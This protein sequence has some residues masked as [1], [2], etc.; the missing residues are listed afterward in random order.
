MGELRLLSQTI[1]RQA[2]EATASGSPQAMKDL[3]ES[4][5]TFAKNIKMSKI[6]MVHLQKNIKS[7]DSV[8][9]FV[10]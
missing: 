7:S 6:F 1:S 3:V 5:Q 10:L 8:E 9:I 2:T 4:R